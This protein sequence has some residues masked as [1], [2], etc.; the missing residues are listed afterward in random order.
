MKDI[1]VT[2]RK[3]FKHPMKLKKSGRLNSGL[4]VSPLYKD[5]SLFSIHFLFIRTSKFW[6]EAEC[7]KIL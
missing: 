7:S 1:S 2:F 6:A 4:P 5:S 3:H